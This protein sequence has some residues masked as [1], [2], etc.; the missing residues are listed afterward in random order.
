[1]DRNLRLYPVYQACLNAVFWVPVFFLF[2]SSVVSLPE[3]LLLESIYYAGVVVL[4][5][6]SG[7]FS[8]LVG[9]KVTLLISMVAWSVAGFIFATTS[10]FA[11]FAAAQLLLSVG[12]AFNSGTDTAL[13]FESLRVTNRESDF[14]SRE[15]KALAIGFLASALAALVGG[16][17]G[18]IDLRLP[19][20]LTGITAFA[21]IGITLG[22]KEPPRTESRDKAHTPGRQ[23]I[24]CVTRL[25]DRV[26]LWI[27][28][29]AIGIT[30][31]NHVPW[32]F[33]QPYLDFLL[34]GS[35]G[36]TYDLTPAA[37]GVVVAVMMLISYGASKQAIWIRDRVG[38]PATLLGTLII[39]G[40]IITAMMIVHPA[41]VILI[42]LRA[43]PRAVMTPVMNAAIHPRLESRIRATYL[44]MQSLAGRLAF[45]GSLL[46]A[47]LAVGGTESL[48]PPVLR[49]ILTAF[50]I[51]AGGLLLLLLLML[52]WLRGRWKSADTSTPA[53]SSDDAP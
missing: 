41:I 26:L 42:L 39:Q 10:T 17:I 7:Y 31:L 37:S 14:G 24:T 13:L 46:A 22:F 47:S 16:L 8:D 28:V 34:A 15:A 44:S 21:G 33:T 32:E 53:R 40:A 18:G 3:V 1:M 43:V 2:F 11:W 5:V 48:T 19:Y 51:G 49:E 50:S 52:P 27:F 38:V 4:E 25:G 6:P 29:F 9:R 20:V 30:V 12:M 45:S 36:P 23:V 35:S